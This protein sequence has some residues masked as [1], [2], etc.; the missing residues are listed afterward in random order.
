MNQIKDN[1][2][3]FNNLRVYSKKLL[4]SDNIVQD[5]KELV[6]SGDILD[7]QS[8]ISNQDKYIKEDYLEYSN[9]NNLN[10]LD[11]FLSNFIIDDSF[12]LNNIN[13]NDEKY[14]QLN[15]TFNDVEYFY[16]YTHSNDNTVFSNIDKTYT[17]G[18]RLYLKNLLENPID[19]INILNNRQSILSNLNNL[20]NNFN[21][22]LIINKLNNNFELIKKV[23]KNVHW[24]L[25]QND[26]EMS[27]MIDMLYFNQYLLKKLNNIPVVLTITNLYKIVLSPMIGILTPIMYVIIPYLVLRFKFK[28]RIGFI[29]YVKMMY[30]YYIKLNFVDMLSKTNSKI[31]IIKNI[32]TCFTM[33]FYFNGILNSIEISRLTLKINN[34]VCTQ[35]D[36]T[37]CMIKNS[38]D[39]IDKLYKK[40]NIE[41]FFNYLEIDRKDYK[42]YENLYN[43][44]IENNIDKDKDISYI[45]KNLIN[46]NHFG[47][48]LT[49]YKIYD[50]NNLKKLLN[51][52]YQCDVIHSILKLINLNNLS[53][54]EFFNLNN[55]LDNSNEPKIEIKGLCHPCIK[56]NI[57][58]D[59]ILS[60]KNNLLITGPNAGGKSTF[61]KSICINI[62]LSQT[63]TYNYCDKIKLTPFYYIASQ[64]NIVDEKG[65]HSLF[66]SEMYRILNNLNQVIKN[67]KENKLS[68]LFL[69]ELFNSTNVIEGISGSYSICKKLAS[70]NNN[71]TLL[72]THFTYLYKLEKDSNFKNYKMNAIVNNNNIV[73]PYK[74]LPGYSTQ[75]IAIELLKNENNLEKYEYVTKDVFNE[76]IHFKQKLLNLNHT[77]KVEKKV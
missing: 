24:M 70:L 72:T 44:N 35:I 28:L 21:N 46:S 14:N 42:I 71:I 3:L 1:I 9:Y 52:V 19:D 6:V 32:W 8:K 18:G 69:D 53:Q 62:L 17:L 20:L 41:Y 12:L 47:K 65:V 36:N 59:I 76:A 43:E 30:N 63:I 67:N 66:E 57:K 77:K 15:N 75:Y 51:I 37:V 22:K 29:H 7:N 34:F 48:K 5:L 40:E 11:N 50:K 56:N 58:N 10:N 4:N 55:K 49:L 2:N 61:I 39:I 64:M 60:N 74:L 54:T 13:N 45:L 38:F 31:K 73:F 68:I 23:E 27:I 33:L 26:D 16:N 25:E